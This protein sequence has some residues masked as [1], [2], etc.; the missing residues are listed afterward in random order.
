[1]P[2]IYSLRRMPFRGAASEEWGFLSFGPRKRWVE[3]KIGGGGW[4][5]ESSRALS[6]PSLSLHG[7]LVNF[8]WRFWQRA[9]LQASP[10]P[11]LPILL[12]N[13]FFCTGKTPKSPFFTRCA[14]EMLA[15]SLYSKRSF[16]PRSAK[17]IDRSPRCLHR[18]TTVQHFLFQSPEPSAICTLWETAEKHD[19]EASHWS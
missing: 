8:S 7:V 17:T 9:I 10:T 18:A 6:P 1:M 19:G 5:R 11:I 16:V 14:T 3:S 12:L 13:H 4:G 2:V 15:F